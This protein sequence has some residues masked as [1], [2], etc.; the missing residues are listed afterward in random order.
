MDVSE[1]RKM[2]PVIRRAD[3]EDKAFAAWCAYGYGMTFGD[4]LARLDAENEPPKS[5]A[6]IYAAVDSWFEGR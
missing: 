4:Y 3:F 5:Q 2:L 6:E 1:A